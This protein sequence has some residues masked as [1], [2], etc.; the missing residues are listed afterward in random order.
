MKSKGEET[1]ALQLRALKINDYE[2]EYLFAKPRRFRFDFAWPN[3][4][5]GIAVEI[6]GGT[7]S[8]GRHNRG[9]GFVN[10]CRKYNLAAHLGWKVFRFT[11]D[12]VISGEAIEFIRM[13]L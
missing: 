9:S 11:T 8:A 1:F 10:D 4:P 6:E 12:M 3:K 2:R 13:E 5:I 7:W